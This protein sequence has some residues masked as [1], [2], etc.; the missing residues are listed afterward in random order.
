M[1]RLIAFMTVLAMAPFVADARA[2]EQPYVIPTILSM[3]GTYGFLGEEES[4]FIA[5]LEQQINAAGGVRGRAVHFDVRDDQSSPQVAVQ[6]ATAIAAS[7][8][9][10]FLGPT[11]AASCDAVAPLVLKN[12]PTMFCLS[13]SFHPPAGSYGFASGTSTQDN[14]AAMVR[15]FRE[16]GKKK[17]AL[18]TSLDASGQD[19]DRW[20]KAALALPENHGI[21]VVA[22]EHFASSDISVSAQMARIKQ[23]GAEALLAWSP[24]TPFINVVHAYTD[25]GL[26]IPIGTSTANMSYKEMKQLA[27][28]NDRNL[29]FT[30]F[31]YFEVKTLRNGPLKDRVDAFYR[32]TRGAGLKPDSMAGTSWDG[33][34]LVVSALQKLGLDTNATAIRDYI[35]GQKSWVGINGIYNFSDGSQR[36]LN[37]SAATIMH[38]DPKQAVWVPVSRPGGAPL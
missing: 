14:I 8:V 10:V 22:M 38:W 12:G 3:T 36:G 9:P 20:F 18:L 31:R 28:Y 37:S 19:G 13:P 5:A 16:S 21:D 4:R 6:L 29:Y 33:A 27:P 25:A 26:T 1:R 35:E 32:A 7:K 34:L 23:S 30:G 15:Y 24:G 2:A 11:I 17:L